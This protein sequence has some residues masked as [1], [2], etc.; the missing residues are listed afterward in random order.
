[1]S[2]CTR[3]R[4]GLGELAEQL[5]RAVDLVAALLEDHHLLR[6][7]RVVRDPEERHHA[8]LAGRDPRSEVECS[9][10]PGPPDGESQ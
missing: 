3:A 7:V 2:K 1:M 4:G 8:H 6:R 9:V 10:Y 5:V